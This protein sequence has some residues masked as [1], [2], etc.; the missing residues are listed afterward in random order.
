[1]GVRERDRDIERGRERREEV[2]DQLASAGRRRLGGGTVC[3]LKGQGTQ[4]T[5]QASIII[6][7]IIVKKEI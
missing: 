6:I 4:M 2:Q 1:M 7:I 3:L 5:G